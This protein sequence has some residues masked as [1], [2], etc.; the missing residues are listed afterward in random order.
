MSSKVQVPEPQ[1]TKVEP[2]GLPLEGSTT[3]FRKSFCAQDHLVTDAPVTA[4]RQL[5]KCPEVSSEA[6]SARGVKTENAQSSSCHGFAVSVLHVLY[7]FA[8]LHRKASVKA[9][10]SKICKRL[11]V[12]L[13]MHEVDILRSKKHDLSQEK[14]Q[15][16]TLNKIKERAYHVVIA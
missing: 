4:E 3:V 2:F 5:S 16:K 1:K 14:L 6:R 10:L 12:K 9:F 15:E 13:V 8:G 11:G 7:L